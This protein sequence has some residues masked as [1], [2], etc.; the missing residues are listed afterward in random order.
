M[1]VK[2]PYLDD[3]DAL[4]TAAD[5]GH[6]EFVRAL[7]A[8]GADANM[9]NAF[10]DT[11]LI[12]AARHGHASIIELLLAHGADP[13]AEDRD[14]DTALDIARHHGRERTAS[15]LVA[16]GAHEGSGPSA[17]DLMMEALNRKQPE[18][19]AG[20][21]SV[22]LPSSVL[23]DPYQELNRL[24]EALSHKADGEGVWRM[25]V[26]S[27]RNMLGADGCT[28]YLVRDGKL[29]V[30]V[31]MSHS[32]H[33]ALDAEENGGSIAEP[34]PIYRPDG[35]VDDSSLA[36]VCAACGEPVNIPDVREMPAWTRTLRFDERLGYLTVSVLS[37]PV[38]SRGRVFGVLQFVNALDA[39]GR[40]GP[41]TAHHEGIAHAITTLM[42]LAP[43]IFNLA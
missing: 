9:T 18:S 24:S 22:R 19:L 29:H 38:L 20:K 39:G 41:F 8:G 17:K 42:S 28:L 10:G 1:I 2:P 27:G 13:N 26:E 32:L 37:V 34:T 33:I 5:Q 14:G 35:G 11:A 16:H 23:K 6:Y 12:A 40:V 3:P 7:V 21:S 4:V 25:I 36:A 30:E 31:L 15:M 43:L